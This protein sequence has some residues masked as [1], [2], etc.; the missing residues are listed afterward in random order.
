MSNTNKRKRA[1]VTFEREKI[2]KEA[3]GKIARKNSKIVIV[4]TED[5]Q[6]KIILQEK[7]G[8]VIFR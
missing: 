8:G 7:S 2:F 5:R 3:K 1:S 6:W 4:I